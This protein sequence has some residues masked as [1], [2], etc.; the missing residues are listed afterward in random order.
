MAFDV[1]QRVVAEVTGR[2][3]RSQNAAMRRPR[4]G[5]VEQVLRGDPQ[6][7]YVVKWDQGGETTFSP[8]GGGLQA[9]LSA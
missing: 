3:Q 6:P 2:R 5:V 1:G 9:E 8:S 4:H 7:R